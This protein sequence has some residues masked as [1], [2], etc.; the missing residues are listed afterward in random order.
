MITEQI[1][2]RRHEPML[3]KERRVPN[4]NRELELGRNLLEETRKSRKHRQIE[5]RRELKKAKP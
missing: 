1:V 3:R 2:V 4:F 5:V